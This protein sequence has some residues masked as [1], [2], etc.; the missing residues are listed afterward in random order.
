MPAW[1]QLQLRPG[2]CVRVGGSHPG[3]L[4]GGWSSTARAFSVRVGGSHHGLFCACWSGTAPAFCVRLGPVRPGLLCV[5]ALW[6]SS[7]RG[8]RNRNSSFRSCSSFRLGLSPCGGRRPERV[9]GV[10][11]KGAVSFRK[12]SLPFPQATPPSALGS[13]IVHFNSP[14]PL[15]FIFICHVKC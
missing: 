7:L 11:S 5:L 8:L 2:F 6:R 3:L 14:V 12:G 13:F 10:S 9:G 4:C 15:R 1:L